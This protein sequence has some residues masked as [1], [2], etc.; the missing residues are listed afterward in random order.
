MRFAGLQV[1][2]LICQRMAIAGRDNRGSDQFFIES[3]LNDY[4]MISVRTSRAKLCGMG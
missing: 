4:R 2:S 1:G 3:L